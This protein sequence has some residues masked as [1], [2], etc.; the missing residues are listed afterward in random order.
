MDVTDGTTGKVAA[1]LTTGDRRHLLE[2]QPPLH[3]EPGRAVQPTSAIILDATQVDQEI[4][5]FGAALTDSAA[6]VLTSYLTAG[7][8][9]HLLQELFSPTDGIGLG[10]LRV[11]VGA[12][13]FALYHYTY[14]DMPAGQRDPELRHF[15]IAHD[16]AYILPI[17][18]SVRAINPHLKIMASPWSPPGWMKR[19]W[20][21]GNPLYGGRLRRDCYD[22]YARYLVAFVRA[23]A[24][25]GVG[26]DALTVQNE[27][28]HAS[29][30]YPSM[31]MHADEQAEFIR[32]H[33]GPALAR[34]G[35]PTKIVI[36]DHNW[37]NPRYPIAVL[38][39]PGA[40]RYVAGTAF[41]GYSFPP[42]PEAQSLVRAAH[43]DRDIYFTECTGLI[44]SD[45]ARDLRW[46]MRY[47][48]I[49]ATRHGA[50]A[51]LLWNLALDEHGEPHT[52]AWAQCRGVVTVTA[53]GEVE[54]NVEYYAL[55][56]ASR[57][58]VPG[59]RRIAATS[60]SGQ[61]E[62]VAFQNPDG[63][64]VLI[65]LNDGA[66]LHTF[67]RALGR[68]VVLLCAGGRRG[69][70]IHMAWRADACARRYVHRPRARTTADRHTR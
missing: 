34:A 8:R 5:G 58:V 67:T 6:W 4:E 64:K 36:W 40:K 29:P 60:T 12:S 69:G 56:H 49:G 30:T 7:A 19:R 33:L 31:R 42:R 44:G 23:Y 41:H 61:I 63:T 53:K 10:Y 45:F 18:R 3:F 65:A 70:D 52:G 43:P 32:Q 38:N 16:E 17:L 37:S 28:E 57:F 27:P 13:D 47:L 50:R 51:V 66:N 54:R 9:E 15:S 46:I 11:P 14:D 62:T 35:L 59:A 2:P 21:P 68:R 39:D 25:A 55:G 26:I 1:W 48:L 22:I 24:D 20:L